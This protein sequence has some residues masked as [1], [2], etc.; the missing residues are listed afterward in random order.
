MIY[1]YSS[2]GGGSLD[3]I[4]NPREDIF[5]KNLDSYPRSQYTSD[6]YPEKDREEDSLDNN[7]Q[8]YNYTYEDMR[9]DLY[10]N[11]DLENTETPNSSTSYEEKTMKRYS[12][13]Q[14]QIDQDNKEKMVNNII[15]I[16]AIVGVGYLAMKML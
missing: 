1:E 6:Y 8:P 4:T 2:G 14:D 5:Q 3:P 16:G 9:K 11:F 7:H 12:A 10:G 13:Y 15:K